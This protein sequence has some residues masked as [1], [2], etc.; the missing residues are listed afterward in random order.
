MK[1]KICHIAE[2]FDYPKEELEP[3][4]YLILLRVSEEQEFTRFKMMGQHVHGPVCT[5]P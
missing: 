2:L 3:I 4:M 5:T 1:G